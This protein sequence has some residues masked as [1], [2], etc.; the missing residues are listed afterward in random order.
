MSTQSNQYLMLAVR[1][2]YNNDTYQ[3]YEKYEDSPYKGIQH[4]KGLAVKYDGRDGRYIFI[5]RVLQKSEEGSVIAGP[6]AIEPADSTLVETVKALIETQFGI[7]D[8]DVKLWLFE[9]LS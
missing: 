6:I 8:A 7:I 4:Y 9:H 2:P 3:K 5:G 1:I